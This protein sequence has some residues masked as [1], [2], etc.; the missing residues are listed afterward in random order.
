MPSLSSHLG[1]SGASAANKPKRTAATNS[2]SSAGTFALGNTSD[3]GSSDAAALSSLHDV[4]HRHAVARSLSRDVSALTSQPTDVDPDTLPRRKF[5][6]ERPPIVARTH[7][8]RTTYD[9]SDDDDDTNA[10]TNANTNEEV[11]WRT[12]KIEVEKIIHADGRVTYPRNPTVEFMGKTVKPDMTKY[13]HLPPG[14]PLPPGLKVP[15]WTHMPEDV[16]APPPLPKP[17]ANDPELMKRAPKEVEPTIIP[18]RPDHPAADP[19]KRLYRQPDGTLGKK[20][21]PRKPYTVASR[22]EFAD[23]CQYA[24]I[25]GGCDK[26]TE[27]VCHRHGTGVL[28][29]E[30]K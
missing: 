20:R 8:T 25:N 28:W 17:E 11:N 27:G 6:G 7:L 18:P 15:G 14:A 30:H 12:K 23:L 9:D 19:E 13:E 24:R 5:S 16:M 22:R 3:T 1:G 4:K 10:N 21:P 29:E 2:D 26:C